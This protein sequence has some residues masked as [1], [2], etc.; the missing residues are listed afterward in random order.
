MTPLNNRIVIVTFHYSVIIRGLEKNLQE[1]NYNVIAVVT[2]SQ[3][4]MDY[5]GR[6]DLFIMYLAD[7]TKVSKDD[8]TQ[9]VEMIHVVEERKQKMIVIG[10]K[11]YRDALAE[12][13][14][15]LKNF[16]YLNRPFDMEKLLDEIQVA[17]SSEAHEYTLKKKILIVDDDP[18][19]SKSVREWVSDL[20][21]VNMVTSGM[22]AIKYVGTNPV[23]L[24][25]LDY[26]MPVVDG[27]QVFEMLRSDPEIKRVP[28][29]FL[30]SVGTREGVSR[31]M[32]LKPDGYILK[33]TTRQDLIQKLK[34]FFK[35]R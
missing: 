27:P 15:G 23:D 33:S 14:P 4:V 10:E 19:Y 22:Q 21:L 32:A 17:I 29:I 16:V 13:I 30:T 5:A 11:G 9:L 7:N 31:V 8:F 6:A 35:N 18:S 34:D 1:K 28:I 12:G 3:G 2:D 25:L 20:Y 24:I 26:E